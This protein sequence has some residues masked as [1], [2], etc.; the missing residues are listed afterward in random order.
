MIRLPLVLV[1]AWYVLLTDC[2]IVL[3][4]VYLYWRYLSK[5]NDD[6]D[7]DDDD[8]CKTLGIGNMWSWVL[9]NKNI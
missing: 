2:I 7:D 1:W 6:D 5:I 8:Q 4:P 9:N 3:C